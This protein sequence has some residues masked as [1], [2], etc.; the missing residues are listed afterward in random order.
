MRIGINVG[1]LIPQ[2]SG[3]MEWYVRCL[4]R[5]LG[6]LDHD[7]D[8]VLVTGF[9][10]HHL[11][12]PPSPRWKCVLYGGRETGAHVYREVPAE[13][14]EP[15]LWY[16]MLRKYYRM[17]RGRPVAQCRRL[18]ELLQREKIDVW[19]CPFMFYLPFD[20]DVP[21]VHTIAD[22]QHEH[23][24]D[25]FNELQL[26]TRTL[27]YQ[28]SCKA[29]AATI[30]ISHF[31]ADDIKRL[32]GIDPARVFAIPLALD[33][34]MQ[35]A[36]PR[37]E[38][39]SAQARLKYRLHGDYIFYPANGWPHKNHETLVR[40]MR[41]V[42]REVPGVR[43]VL[44]GFAYDVL[45]RIQPILDEHGLHDTVRY[46]G[47]V[48]RDDLVGL[49]A[50]A[51]MLV[52]PSLFEGFGLPLLEAMH[53]GVPVACS[54]MGSLPEVAGGATLFF[55]PRDER[56]IAESILRIL[57]DDGLRQRLIDAGRAQV[58]RFSYARTAQETLEVFRKVHAGELP[59]PNLPTPRPLA[60]GKL[61]QD[62]RCRWFF[63][64]TDLRE[65]R[66]EAAPAPGIP[67]A[68][69]AGQEQRLEIT[70]DGEHVLAAPLPRRGSREFVIRPG[71]GG[72]DGAAG[73][74]AAGDFH[75]LEI[76]AS[77]AGLTASPSPAVH[78]NQII[79]LDSRAR[80]T[81]LVA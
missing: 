16:R 67:G 6:R 50:G 75:A 1:N 64:H 26:A 78:I 51:K 47:Y 36:A 20:T 66:V 49:Y 61:L 40:A 76:V 68:A 34:H 53:L 60:P 19:F 54:R 45:D 31:V 81:R 69:A 11:F 25:F 37:A 43:L 4:V 39:L 24:P 15:P 44:S 23:Y 62:G 77:H 71:A 3:G 72:A 32:Y 27:G 29:S 55:D 38:R 30:A 9:Q 10:N 7:N 65:L 22:L 80:K 74:A 35:D 46:V 17:V 63:R 18:S 59:R 73:A 33:P 48:T 8:Y 70:L 14:P 41:W 79:A 28:F 5:E 2:L 13:P 42:A 58:A 56:D 52:F 57:G 21:V 12:T